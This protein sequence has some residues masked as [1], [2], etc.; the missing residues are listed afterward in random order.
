MVSA[1]LLLMA[2]LGLR[3]SH[4]RAPLLGWAVLGCQPHSPAVTGEDGSPALAFLQHS[5]GVKGQVD[6]PTR[7][8]LHCGEG[9]KQKALRWKGPASP[10]EASL[11]GLEGLCPRFLVEAS[12]RRH[13]G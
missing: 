8:T 2:I 4:Q 6:Q 12:E 11:E 5:A 10:G 7:G 1:P 13:L 9:P 3:C